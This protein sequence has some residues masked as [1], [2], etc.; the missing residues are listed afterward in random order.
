MLHFFGFGSLPSQFSYFWG[1]SVNSVYHLSSKLLSYF[2]LVEYNCNIQS[3]IVETNQI[4]VQIILEQ[5][6]KI[7]MS[8]LCLWGSREIQM[9]LFFPFDSI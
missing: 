2:L 4:N 8:C 6:R 5:Q 1:Y 3:S 9:P 7:A